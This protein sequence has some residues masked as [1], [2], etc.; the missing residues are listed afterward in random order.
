MNKEFSNTD[1]YNCYGYG[2]HAVVPHFTDTACP[3]AA[4]MSDKGI[5]SECR[6][7]CKSVGKHLEC[8]GEQTCTV[9]NGTG[10]IPCLE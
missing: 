1:C 4:E 9:C 10:K 5:G 6:E 8:L 3:F 7:I 2:T